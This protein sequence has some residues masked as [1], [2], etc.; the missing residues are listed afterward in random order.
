MASR[1]QLWHVQEM[2]AGPVV[3]LLH[4]A[5]GAT[6]SF[7]H[8]VPLLA[9]THRVIAIDLPGQGFTVLGARSRCGL[10]ATAE[11]IK[12]LCGQEGWQP[13]ALIGHSAGAALA[14]RVA[15]IM[16]VGAVVGINAALGKFDGVAGWVF[17]IMAKVL[18]L[19][20]LVATLFSK[21]AGTPAQVHQLLM[22][23]GSKI[24]RE[25]EAQYLHLL[26]MASHVDATLSM[27]SQ[28]ELGGLLEGL[29]RQ[30]VSCLLITASG[31]RAVPA[32]VSQKAAALMPDARW[33]DLPGYGHLVHEE[34][35]DKVV[36]LI[37]NFLRKPDA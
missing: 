27:M 22:A 30:K 10:N 21:Y 14:L 3:L 33:V 32:T 28:W 11:D 31:D 12:A 19:T 25:G 7:R 36:P 5:G 1:P 34:A 16:P 4:G 17:P 26:R 23:T 15:Q 6:H 9:Q 29:A 37:L 8:L 2:G 24:D 35:A 18:A 20:P 13:V